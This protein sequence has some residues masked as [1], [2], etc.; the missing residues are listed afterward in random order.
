MWHCIFGVWELR[1]SKYE[2]GLLCYPTCNM[3]NI[4]L[5]TI[6]DQWVIGGGRREMRRSE[7]KEEDGEWEREDRQL[8]SSIFSFSLF[9]IFFFFFL[10]VC[11]SLTVALVL[12]QGQGQGHM[13]M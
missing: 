1:A 2:A 8:V 5:V 9:V 11:L 10:C 13:W 4:I 12:D 6:M 3:D 7:E